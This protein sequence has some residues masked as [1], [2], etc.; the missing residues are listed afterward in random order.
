MS[1][2]PVAKKPPVAP[3]DKPLTPMQHKFVRW[4][5]SE[6][7][8]F[9]GVMAAQKAG[10]KGSY[11][12]LAVTAHDNLKKPNIKKAVDAAMK[13]ALDGADCTVEGTLRDLRQVYLM[14]IEAGQFSAAKGAAEL[15][16]KYLKMFTDRIEH[17]E[18]I[19]EVSLEDLVT[20]AKDIAE[21]NK[22]D[23]GQLFTGNGS[24][25][26]AASDTAGD[27]TTH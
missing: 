11:N 4:Y 9:N 14:A 23:F 20:L 12:T 8:N 19:D 27:Q 10:Y 22:I 7:C 5:V 17:V 13:E 24:G 2:K 26:G 25:G 16:G 1:K 18:T 6:I 21:A 15:R 3:E